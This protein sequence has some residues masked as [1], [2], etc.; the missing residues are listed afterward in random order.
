MMGNISW[1]TITIRQHFYIKSFFLSKGCHLEFGFWWTYDWIRHECEK[2]KWILQAYN[3]G[4]L[5]AR[6]KDSLANGGKQT[7]L[8]RSLPNEQRPSEGSTWTKSI[9]PTM[10]IVSLGQQW[11]III[12]TIRRDAQRSVWHSLELWCDSER[13]IVTGER[14]LAHYP[15]HRWPAITAKL[16][17]GDKS[18]LGMNTDTKVSNLTWANPL[19]DWS[20]RFGCELDNERTNGN[21]NGQHGFEGSVNQSNRTVSFHQVGLTWIHLQNYNPTIAAKL[22]QLLKES[23]HTHAHRQVLPLPVLD[24]FVHK[25]LLSHQKN[26]LGP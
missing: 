3:H 4:Q 5:P 18:F 22:W 19:P 1:A 9:L 17:I 20:I 14:P 13:P 2:W 12:I 8:Q 26:T 6:D 24:H 23:K 11:A 15:A 21:Y 7:S 16:V 10:I 25:L